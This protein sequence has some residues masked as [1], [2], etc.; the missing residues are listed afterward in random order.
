MSE[1]RLSLVVRGR[2]WYREKFSERN[3]RKLDERLQVWFTWVLDRLPKPLA[4]RLRQQTDGRFGIGPQVRTGLGLGVLL[5]LT[6]SVVALGFMLAVNQ[7]HREIADVQVPGLVAAFEVRDLSRQLI[8]VSPRF[9]ASDNQ[10]ALSIVKSDIQVLGDELRFWIDELVS[11]GSE[12]DRNDKIADLAAN[13]LMNLDAIGLTTEVRMAQR[14]QLE[15]KVAEVEQELL[16][17]GSY[18]EDAK[19]RQYFFIVTGWRSLGDVAPVSMGL[20]RSSAEVDNYS[21]LLNADASTNSMVTL[22]LQAATEPTSE[23][24]LANRERVNTELADVERH[25]SDLDGPLADD[26]AAYLERL[27]NLYTLPGGIYSTRILELEEIEKVATLTSDNLAAADSL[28]LQ[29]ETLRSEA[30]AST[31]AATASSALVVRTGFWTILA[32]NLVAVVAAIVFGWKFFGERLLNRVRHLSG[33]MARMSGGELDVEV[34]IAGNDELSDMA[35]A[36]EVFRRHA[37]E[38]QRLNLVEKLVQEVQAKNK[39]LEQTLLDLEETQEQ[40]V[41]QEKLASLGALTAGIAHEIRNPLNFVNNFAALSRELI[42][43]MQEELGTDGEEGANVPSS[44]RLAEVDWEYV[45]ELFG[46]LTMNVTKVRE[47]GMRANRIVEGMLAH[48]R[49]ETADPEPVK[50]NQLLDEYAKLAY[51]GLR[52]TNPE[53]NVTL[54]REFDDSAGEMTAIARDLSRVFLNIITN[55][56]HA[57][58]SRRRQEQGG[59]YSPTIT[60]C[61][62]GRDDEVVVAIRDN[63]TGMPPEVLEKIFDPFFTTKK[64]TEGTGLGLSITHEII[65]EHGGKLEVDTEVDEFTE[66]RIT[67]PR[68]HLKPAAA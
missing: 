31:E 64:G 2:E 11:S 7:H 9:A 33:S 15:E 50:V 16:E 29:V 52:A 5:T 65:Q 57:T 1:E 58:D 6:A 36:L 63:G 35:G 34:R 55:A 60:L 3:L 56:C 42:E 39:E 12:S 61:T 20:R 44:E 13:L 27:D 47:H 62:E 17:F 10:E 14:I 18:M 26:L 40:V 30:Q 68:V 59:G 22:M 67:L 37:I 46:D 38:V 8:G 41:R 48:S 28:V 25:L 24:L 19:D 45:D 49:E 21:A 43:E 23:N 53:F 54:V 66:F 51:H 4:R 32:F